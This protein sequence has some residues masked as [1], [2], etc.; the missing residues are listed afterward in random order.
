MDVL[1]RI[2]ILMAPSVRSYWALVSLG[3][4]ETNLSIF[5]QYLPLQ[6]GLTGVLINENQIHENVTKYKEADTCKIYYTTK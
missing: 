2:F 1:V 5:I 4:R 3:R 6:Q